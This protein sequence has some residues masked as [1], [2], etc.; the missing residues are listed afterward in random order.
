MNAGNAALSE[1]G[2]EKPK[3]EY[4]NR[5]RKIRTLRRI[6]SSKWF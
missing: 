5:L 3:Y 1:S 4:A 6:R 2:G